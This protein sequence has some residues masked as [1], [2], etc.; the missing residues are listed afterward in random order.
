VR[1]HRGIRRTTGRLPPGPRSPRLVQAVLWGLRYP[2]FTRAAR[3]R[4]GPTFTVRP[5]TSPPVVLTTD[6]DAI[7]RLLTGPPLE[8]HHG[9]DVLRP[10]IGDRSILLLEP[11]EH[12]ERRKLLLPPFH[13]E[14][15]RAY[16]A[17]MQRLV[18]EEVDRWR[19]GDEVA[20]L[21]LAQDLTMEV[22]LQAVLGVADPAMRTRLRRLIDDTLG[23]PFGGLR[24]RVG[25][26]PLAGLRLPGR[27]QHAGAL[28]AGLPTPAVTTYFP[29]FKVRSR[30][31][32]IVEPWWC[33][34]D[35]LLAMLDE[36]VAATRADPGLA[37]RE[38]I[39]ALLMRARFEDGNGL[40]DDDLRDELVAL[41]AAGHETTAAA[42]AWGAVLLAHDRDVRERAAQAAHA[43]DE[44]Y[45]D[46]LVKEVLRIRS[47]LSGTAARRL[48]AP[49]AIGEHTIPPG[50]L[51]L[52]DGHGL[53]H[54]PAL[55]PEPEALRP[56]RFLDGAP[57]PYTWLPFGGGAHRC[58]GAALAELEIKVALGTMLRRIDLAPATRELAPAVR[59][60]LTLVP[61]GG[62]RVRVAGIAAHDAEAPVTVGA[63]A[64]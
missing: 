38:D 63:R 7:R 44:R 47:P 37:E 2:E 42:I 33:H 51:I 41:I 3:A 26:T 64:S 56:E 31:N 43:G 30:R 52:V 10:L 59:R 48:D 9:N 57:E 25:G 55:F 12:L 1:Q 49:F 35:E 29:E 39:L 27:L 23:Y 53:H 8:K 22:I 45:L 58:I 62:G 17:L 19:P 5:G 4:H 14:R 54:D 50:T 15:V 36:Q 32:A 60:G 13:G 40:R 6:R 21:P 24:R 34:R 46:A 28:L 18:D 16:A 20:V 61:L 11:A